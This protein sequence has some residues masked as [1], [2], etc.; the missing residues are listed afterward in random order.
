MEFA[1]RFRGL[2]AEKG[3][4]QREMANLL[5]VSPTTV[6]SWEQEK[7]NPGLDTLVEIA[8]LFD[9]SVDYLLGLTDSKVPAEQYYYSVRELKHRGF[10][11]AEALEDTDLIKF[12][13]KMKAKNITPEILEKVIPLILEL[14]DHL[15]D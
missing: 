10:M 5:G 11:V 2:R 3:W 4:T 7:N 14:K 9:V 1:R 15:R 6:A 12:T 13:R 8:H